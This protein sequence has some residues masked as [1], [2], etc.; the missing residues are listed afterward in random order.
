MQVIEAGDVTGN[1]S[2]VC[3]C[4][5]ERV[6]GSGSGGVRVCDKHVLGS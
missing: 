2:C 5:F 4:V 3:V 1:D 6:Y